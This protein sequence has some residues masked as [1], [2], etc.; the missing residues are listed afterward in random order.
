MRTCLPTASVGPALAGGT[1]LLSGET[2]FLKWQQLFFIDRR[3]HLS[4]DPLSGAISRYDM[5]EALAATHTTLGCFTSF[6]MFL[7]G[8][9]L[10]DGDERE[11]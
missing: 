11:W 9:C 3:P 7:N 4:L 5:T 8:T 2:G 6:N 1:L 10:S